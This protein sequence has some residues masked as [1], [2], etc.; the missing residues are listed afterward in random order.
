MTSL[1]PHL[2]RPTLALLL[3]SAAWQPVLAETSPWY[4]GAS[5]ALAHESN[6]YRIA[7]SETLTTPY[8]KADT[9]ATTSLLGGLDQQWGRQHLGATASIRNSRY[10][11]NSHLN[12]SGYGLNAALD[13][14]TA[15]RLSGRLS[16]ASDQNLAQFNSRDSSNQ[17]IALRNVVRA[18]QLDATARLGT[19]TRLTLEAGAGYRS[20]EYSASRYDA[21]DSRQTYGSLGVRWRSSPALQ[22]GAAL[23]LTNGRY[24]H[25]PAADGSGAYDPDTYRRTDLD[26]SARWTPSGA[27]DLSVRVSPTRTRYDRDTARNLSGLTGLVRWDWQ[28]GGKL[29]LSSKLSRDNGQSADVYNLGIFGQGVVDYGRTT[30][31]LQFSAAYDLSAKVAL[32]ASIGRAHRSLVDTRILNSTV[33][34]KAAGGDDTDTLALG[35]RWAPVR[36]ALLGCDLNV[37]NRHANSSLSWSYGSTSVSCYGQATLQ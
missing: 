28:P 29:R 30:T 3:A 7:S 6:L 15:N 19:V 21:Y 4:L 22:L 33:L 9:V 10:Q 17:L 5:Q 35:A 16:V 2:S 12:N 25:F 14:E 1:R 36:W 26:L 20:R 8:S 11:N 34:S 27:T 13:W 31:A 24:P 18:N 23:R 37:D 32:N